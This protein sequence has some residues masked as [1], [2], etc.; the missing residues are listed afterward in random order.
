VLL[1]M[2]ESTYNESDG[3]TTDDDH[4]ISWCHRYDGGRAWYTGLGHTE[5]SYLEPEFLQHV[6]GGI[7]IASGF[8]ADDTCGIVARQGDAGGVVPATLSLSLGATAS[9]GAFIPGV[10]RSYSAGTSA[11]VIS[12]AGDALLSVTDPSSTAT[13]RLV[14]GTFALA[15]PLEAMASSAGGAGGALAPLSDDGSPLPLLT[16][17]RPV[18]NDAVSVTLQQSIGATEALRTGSYS[19]TLTFTLSTTNP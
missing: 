5:A 15:Q 18:S 11:N 8:V 16:Y 19:K 9:F 13:G 1:K 6:L 4:P 10:A 17:S 3:S 12:S 14:N 7:E 2:D